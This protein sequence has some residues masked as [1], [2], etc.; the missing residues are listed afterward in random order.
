MILTCILQINTKSG[1]RE[2]WSGKQEGIGI[3]EAAHGSLAMT[4]MKNITKIC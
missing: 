3:H 4:E 2:L 1:S